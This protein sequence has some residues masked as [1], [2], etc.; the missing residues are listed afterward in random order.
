MI[1]PLARAVVASSLAVVGGLAQPLGAQPGSFA[2]P[3]PVERLA[4]RRAALADRIGNGIAVLSAAPERD[5]DGRDHPQDAFYRQDNDF[6][7]LTGLETPNAWLVIIARDSAPDETMLF[8]APRDTLKERWWGPQITPGAEAQRLTGIRDV[9]P[10]TDARREILRAVR[11][12]QSPARRGALFLKRTPDA[13][14]S[15][16]FRELSEIPDIRL[17][18]LSRTLAVMRLIKDADEVQ[19]IRRATDLTVEGHLAAWRGTRPGAWERQL[20]ADAEATW[21]KLGAERNAYPSI[22]AAGSRRRARETRATS[23]SFTGCRTGS[24]WTRTT[25]APMTSRSGPAWSSRS[26]PESRS[27]RKGS[28]SASRT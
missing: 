18:D 26:N 21:R 6:F 11:A 15:T 4:A 28:A 14:R 7:Y 5:E 24:A 10:N 2:G 25:S 22:V 19:R 3:V 12:G 27:P 8:L 17:E 9:R 13:L 16:L 1:R 20:E 23:T